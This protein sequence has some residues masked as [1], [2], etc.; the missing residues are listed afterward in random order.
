MIIKKYFSIF[1]PLKP[2][3]DFEMSGMFQMQCPGCMGSGALS[4]I[5]QLIIQNLM[6]YVLF[7]C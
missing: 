3:L 2:I 6:K 5:S 7:E 4:L 1:I